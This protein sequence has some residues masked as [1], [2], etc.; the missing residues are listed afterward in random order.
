MFVFSCWYTKKELAARISILYAAGLMAG[1]FSGLLGSAI[2]GGMDGV[3]G[4]S[5][6]RWLFIIE[7]AMT[8]PFAILTVFVMPDYP[9]T[10]KFLSDEERVLAV[11]RMAE[12]ASEEDDR[13]EVPVM[14]G[15]K[16][17]FT[18]PSLYI[19]W[20]MQLGLNTAA[21]FT[22]FFPTIVRTLGYPQRETLLLS[23]PP[24]VFAA[25]L[26][27][28]NSWHSDKTKERWLHVLW[29]QVLCSIGFI[30]SATTLNTAARYTATFMMMSVYGSFGCILSWVSTTLPRPSTKRAVAY[31]TVNAG[32]NFASI[33]ASYFYPSSQGPRYWQ[34]NVANVA[35]SAACMMMATILHFYLS[36][37][38]N[39]LDKAAVEDLGAEGTATGTS[40]MT[41]ASKWQCHP[42][43]RYTL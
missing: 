31:A 1:A 25:I 2:M 5:D 22:N 41:V 20:M 4:I 18:D 33:Y 28:C 9:A 10:S 35:F 39:K 24:Y 34:A 6:W 42:D 23:A 26:G 11:L 14:V 17:A 37:R 12:E 13:A 19:I 21:A 8:I 32:S 3:A 7:G 30:I 36:R 16:M 15:L 43:H 29:P 38:N 27:I 40:A